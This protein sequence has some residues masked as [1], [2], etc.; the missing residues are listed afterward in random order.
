MSATTDSEMNIKFDPENKKGIS[1]LINI[2]SALTEKS[3]EE[4]EKEFEGSNYGNFKAKVAEVVCGEC[5][6]IQQKY[7]E[8]LNSDLI[9]KILDEGKN[10]LLKLTKEKYEI[11]K[12]KLGV[13]R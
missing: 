7:N 8:Y 4:I 13:V 12:N 10:K 1:N 11:M 2:Y 5:A 6:K 3:V 9:D